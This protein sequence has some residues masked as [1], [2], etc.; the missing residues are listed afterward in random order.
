MD[1]LYHNQWKKP[2]ALSSKFQIYV[3]YFL[4]YLFFK[5]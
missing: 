4:I 3:F 5:S 1:V 2:V